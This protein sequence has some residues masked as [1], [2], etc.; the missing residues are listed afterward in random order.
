MKSGT[1]LL[2]WLATAPFVHS[3]GFGTIS[4]TI[5]DPSGAAVPKA[6]VTTTETGTGLT[7]SAV[8]TAEGYFTIPSL[9]PTEYSIEITAD[10]FRKYTRSSVTL[11]AD[12]S[13]TLTVN[14]EVGATTESVLVTADAQQVDTTTQTIR[15]VV[16][17][18]RMVEL[19]LNGRNAAQ[20]TLL[21]AGAVTSTNGGADQ[22]DTKTFPA[23]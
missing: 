22:G 16:D 3:Q 4:G 1:A 7:R 17:E 8:S 9:R 19:P 6:S 13:L 20:L 18:A 21:V 15:E 5:L 14:L 23:P 2:A 12:Q 11:L 10:G